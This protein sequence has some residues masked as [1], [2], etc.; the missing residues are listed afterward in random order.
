[1]AENAENTNITLEL[2]P[3]NAVVRYHDKDFLVAN[4]KPY[5]EY[6]ESNGVPLYVGEFGLYKF[7]FF[8]INHD[9][10]V[11]TPEEKGAGQYVRDVIS[12]FDELGLAYSYHCYHEDGF[13][14]YR[15]AWKSV[16]SESPAKECR[17]EELYQAFVDS[18][19]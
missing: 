1:M 14:L 8:E 11:L 15:D 19:K 10:T 2:I 9:A 18:V 13:G 12:V 5:A 16:P 4:L 6:A 17:I 3:C 7:A